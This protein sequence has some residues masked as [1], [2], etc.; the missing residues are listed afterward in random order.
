MK[1]GVGIHVKDDSGRLRSIYEELKAQ[2][3]S[4]LSQQDRS[5]APHYTIQNKVTDDAKVDQTLMELTDQFH[6]SRG[7]ALGLSLYRY[8]RGHWRKIEDFLF[9]D[10]EVLSDRT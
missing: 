10:E 7:Q 4:F 3:T 1:H 9:G 5:F 6:G 8:D 2:W